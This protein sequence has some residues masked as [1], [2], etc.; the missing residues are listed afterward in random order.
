MKVP[1]IGFTPRITY[2][3]SVRKQFINERYLT[4][5]QNHGVNTIMLTLNNPSD[6]NILDLCDG[7]IVTGGEDLDPSFYK[8]ENNG[9]RGC[10]IPM[11]LGDKK[12]IEYAVKHKKPLLGICRG[13]QSL[14]VFLGGNL[15]QDIGKTHQ[16]K[17]HE[18]LVKNNPFGWEKIITVN[19]YHHQAIKELAK[20]LEAIASSS[21]DSIIEAVVHK[22]LPIFGVQWHPEMA[23]DDGNTQ[24]LFDYFISLLK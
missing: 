24:K 10:D 7:F 9:S 19:S 23:L 1:L 5:F 18:V 17:K 22:E 21:S 6:D 3:G 2:D 4:Y 11:D 15:L 8:E 20:S 13:I 14:N 12:L 16:G